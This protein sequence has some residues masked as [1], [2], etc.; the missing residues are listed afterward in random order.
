MTRAQVAAVLTA[1]G[2]ASGVAGGLTVSLTV[3]LYTA[4]GLLILLGF[5]IGRE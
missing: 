5:V 1:A 3:G 4:C 2:V